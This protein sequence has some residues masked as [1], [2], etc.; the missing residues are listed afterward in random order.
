MYLNTNVCIQQ[1][2]KKTATLLVIGINNGHGLCKGVRSRVVETGE[3]AG[4]GQRVPC[5]I[6][7]ARP[8]VENHEQDK[9]EGGTQ[10]DRQRALDFDPKK[11]RWGSLRIREFEKSRACC[12]DKLETNFSLNFADYFV[13]DKILG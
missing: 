12:G 6:S 5:R 8:V 9:K 1:S 7:N 3:G 13:Q 11:C 10:S 4:I 2:D